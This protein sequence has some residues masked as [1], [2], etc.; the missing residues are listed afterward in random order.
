[1][2]FKGFKEAKHV[3]LSAFND[4]HKLFLNKEIVD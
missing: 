4:P 3:K 1:M 2:F